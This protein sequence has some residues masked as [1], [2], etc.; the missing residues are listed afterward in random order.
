MIYYE[1]FLLVNSHNKFAIESIESF[2]KIRF[3]SSIKKYIS[4]LKIQIFLKLMDH[5]KL[6]KLK[7][8]LMLF[9]M[10]K[11]LTLKDLLI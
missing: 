4:I 11:P 5:L 9:L 3:N 6:M 1:I 8:K 7:Q 10:F 2:K